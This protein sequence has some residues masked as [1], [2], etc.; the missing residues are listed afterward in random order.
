MNRILERVKEF[1]NS[2]SLFK[3]DARKKEFYSEAF[4]INFHRLKFFGYFL[5]IMGLLQLYGDFFLSDFWDTHQISA[6]M[7]LDTTAVFWGLLIIFVSYFRPPKKPAD[8]RSWHRVFFS[9]YLIYH[10]VWA[11]GVSIIEAESANGV[12]TYLI[13]IFA[14]AT[15]YLL[16][17]IPFLLLLFASLAGLYT[18]L[19]LSGMELERLV[20]QYMSTI[21]LIL[22]AWIVSRVLMNTRIRSFK[23]K[24]EIEAARDNLDQTVKERT[25]ELLE[26]NEQ[27]K[28]EIN[29]RE[30]YE[31]SL[32]EAK[33]KAEEADRLKSV[34]LA[35]MSHEIRTPLNGILGFGDLLKNPRLTDEKKVK[36]LDIIS[37]N[38]QQLLKIIDDVMDISMIESNQLNL[39]RV[40]FKLA[41][42]FPEAKVFF[43][44]YARIQNKEHIEI[45][46]EVYSD[47]EEVVLFSDP[48]RVQQ[49]LYNLLSNALKFTQ[50]G[51][52]RFGFKAQNN[53]A[54]VYVEDTGIGIEREIS[55]TIFERFRQGEESFS[56]N[57]GGN[58]LGLSI[59]KGLAEFLGGLLWVDL[60]YHPG[61]RFCFTLPTKELKKTPNGSE[62]E[63]AYKYLNQNTK[64]IYTSGKP[65]TGFLSYFLENDQ[66]FPAVRFND[67]T[68]DILAELPEIILLD[69]DETFV[70]N[71][72]DKLI[73]FIQQV[74]DRLVITLINQR[75]SS[76]LF[77]NTLISSGCEQVQYHPVD[78][79][80]LLSAISQRFLQSSPV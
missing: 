24:K 38:G 53:Y 44:N 69:V 79:K 65:E 55:R 49:I 34:F 42:L 60:S 2:I 26:T 74:N 3:D 41:H 80:L 36:Y 4:L 18:G 77:S 23:D 73:E 32:K 61:A 5:L 43:E 46:N 15:I 6:F 56:R 19:F 67:L 27:L 71:H 76:E 75:E 17:G 11:T 33:R 51:H 64:I 25:T 48:L 29:E 57:Y 52:V 66:E 45:I 16:R 70:R 20:N 40:E 28:R 7:I 13:G 12:P 9:L 54:L 22:I 1:S 31:K 59:S 58:G 47:Q 10:L 21:I 35:N 39:N 37:N 68:A 78:P 72:H 14:M 62:L 50:E 8:I 63:S 30:R